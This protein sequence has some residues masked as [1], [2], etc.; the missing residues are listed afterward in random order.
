MTSHRR[1]LS[2]RADAALFGLA[3]I[4]HAVDPLPGRVSEPRPE[5]VEGMKNGRLLTGLTVARPY[6]VPVVPA[7]QCVPDRL[8]AF[9]EAV[10]MHVPDPGG[11]VHFYESDR[12][13]LRLWNDPERYFEKLAG[14]GGI[15]GY[16]RSL[17]RNLLTGKEISRTI[18]NFLVTAAFHSRTGRAMASVRLSGRDSIPYALAGVPRRSIVALGLTG[19]TKSRENRPHVVEEVRI[20]CDYLEPTGLVVYGSDM[21]HVLDYPR[22]R[23]IPVHLFDPDSRRRSVDRAV[24]RVTDPDIRGAYEQAA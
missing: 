2:Q 16:D 15:L 3:D 1:T 13:I 21:Y 22:E 17:P 10:A 23:G 11:W 18:D 19:C 24:I 7:T 8:I 5:E 9:S 4:P 14:F 12:K 20:I 6:G